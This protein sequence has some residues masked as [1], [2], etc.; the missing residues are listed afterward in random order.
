MESVCVGGVLLV[1][2]Y[3]ILLVY[4]LQ[5]HWAVTNVEVSKT[6]SQR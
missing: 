4:I 3:F 2:F 5:K 6:A 1:N